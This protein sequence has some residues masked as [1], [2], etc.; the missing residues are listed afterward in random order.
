[1]RESFVAII[2][3]TLECR[4]PML[5]SGT[6]VGTDGVSDGLYGGGA[7]DAAG[8]RGGL[9]RAGSIRV[10][11]LYFLPAFADAKPAVKL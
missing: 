3:T 10:Q 1:M 2:P 11:P 6:A 9:Y 7:C 8:R 4:S 5:A